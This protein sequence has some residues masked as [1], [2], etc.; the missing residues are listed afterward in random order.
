MGYFIF[1]NSGTLLYNKDLTDKATDPKGVSAFLSAICAWAKMYSQTGLSLFQTGS[2]KFIFE[3]SIYSK[4]LIFCISCTV[5]HDE[6][7]IHEKIQMMKQNFVHF[8]WEDMDDLNKG[9][10]SSEKIEKF[11]DIINESLKK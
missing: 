4:E 10:I 6:K 11:Q 1:N 9:I 2:M 8:F 5:D 7:D 3:I